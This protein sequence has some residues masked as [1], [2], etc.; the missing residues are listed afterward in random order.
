[1]RSS[2]VRRLAGSP[3]VRFFVLGAA[4]FGLW[5]LR[6]RPAAIHV[7]PALEQALATEREHA[8]GRALTPAERAA[9]TEEWVE[10]EVLFRE[11]LARRLERSDPIVRRR[12]VQAMRFVLEEEGPEPT[13]AELEQFAATHRARFTIPASVSFDQVFLADGEPEAARRALEGGAAPASIGRPFPYG[14][15]FEAQREE[16]LSAA[17]GPAFAARVFALEPNVWTAVDSAFG[18]HLVRVTGRAAAALPPL[19]QIA[20]PVR[21]AMRD[22]R[23]DDAAAQQLASL[24][25]GYPVEL[26]AQ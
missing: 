1:M 14:S 16:E 17:L 22:E 5:E 7:S 18:A 25:A 2:L 21:A 24:R 26:P 8:L 11:A 6:A 19:E 10:E 9:A 13:R 4:L 23:R 12:L 15:R 3:S 20:G